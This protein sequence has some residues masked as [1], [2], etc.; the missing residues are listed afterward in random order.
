LFLHFR[1]AKEQKKHT[2][3]KKKLY[4]AKKYEKF[5]KFCFFNKKT[6][7]FSFNVAHFVDK[8]DVRSSEL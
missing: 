1:I 3:K 2:Q 7:F 8:M 5:G 4:L 6:F